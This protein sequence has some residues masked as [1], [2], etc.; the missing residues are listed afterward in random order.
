MTSL[1]LWK[2]RVVD[3]ALSADEVVSVI[4]VC[5]A[6]C[7]KLSQCLTNQLCQACCNECELHL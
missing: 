4:E 2:H 7:Q 3:Q 6:A 5:V 1:N